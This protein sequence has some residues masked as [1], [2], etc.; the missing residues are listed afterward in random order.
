[1]Q[2]SGPLY[3]ILF[4]LA[5]CVVCGAMVLTAAYSLKDRQDRNKL[6]DR[7][8][9]ILNVA[10]LIESEASASPDEVTTLFKDRIRPQYVELETGKVVPE[11]QVMP[12]ENYNARAVANDPEL[13]EAAP[14]NQ[15]S[16][17]R[18]PKYALVYQ[19]L[20]EA[21]T[22]KDVVLP[23]EGYGLWGTLY[24]YLAVEADG[25]TIAGITY[26]DHKETPGLGGEVDNPDWK[27]LWV[28]RKIYDHDEVTI[29][30]KKG[31]AGSPSEDPYHVNGLSGATITS[32]GVTHMLHF[33]LGENGFKPYLESLS[34][35]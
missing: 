20:D 30:V 31:V 26:Y 1:M 17:M 2:R 28:D 15:S 25:Q 19:V 23:I 16:I 10:G 21:G 35:A 18:I 4:A 34:K 8:K 11:E 22:V 24:G 3:T 13:G 7:Q 33:W 29:S 14:P 5:T 9:K 6:L 12:F 32:N 27:A